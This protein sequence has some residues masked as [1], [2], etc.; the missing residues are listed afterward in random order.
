VV[1]VRLRPR[2]AA[3][4]TAAVTVVAVASPV[5]AAPTPSPSAKSTARPAPAKAAPPAKATPSPLAAGLAA[6]ARALK[7]LAA[8]LDAAQVTLRPLQITA[9]TA[10][11]AWRRTLAQLAVARAAQARADTA[12]ATARAAKD[13]QDARVGQMAASAYK[14]GGNA[15]AWM[16]ALNVTNPTDLFTQ[17]ATLNQIAAQQGVQLTQ[18]GQLQAV[19]EAA[20]LTAHEA[21]GRVFTLVD[22]A[23]RAHD[24]AS[25]AMGAQQK[26]VHELMTR[27]ARIRDG[28]QKLLATTPA[29][30]RAVLLRQLADALKAVTATAADVDA[31]MRAVTALLP[32]AS[33]HQGLDALAWAKKQLGLPYSWGGGNE[34]GP[35]RGTVNPEGNTAGLT[36]TGFDCSGLTLFAWAKEGFALDHFT[37]FQWF[38]G[39]PVTRDELRPGDLVFY[40]TDPNDPT[41]IHHVGIYAGD[42]RMIDAPHTGAKVRYD[43]VF[44]SQYVGAVRP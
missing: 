29:A 41:T 21:A 8:D 4:V 22:Q 20:A 14:S 10:T 23:G 3:V 26:V 37:G 25:A 43:N 42:G 27:Q 9:T 6:Q 1:L 40:A 33:S 17:Q 32:V 19:A 16:T 18:L 28:V 36:T 5:F 7:A 38:E 44:S 13:A 24:A 31:S 2:L 30:Q 34:A 35:T 11:K 15:P 39:R 12:A